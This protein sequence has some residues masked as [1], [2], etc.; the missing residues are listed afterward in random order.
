MPIS[1]VR[2]RGVCPLIKYIHYTKYNA[3]VGIFNYSYQERKWKYSLFSQ[4]VFIVYCLS[5]LSSSLF[6]ITKLVSS[7]ATR[8][9]TDLSWH[10]P[11]RN[12]LLHQSA[13]LFPRGCCR[14]KITLYPTNNFSINKGT[15]NCVFLTWN[16]LT[17]VSLY[18]FLD[19]FKIFCL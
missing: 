16:L 2:I 10:D 5:D 14:I 19:I 17:I 12:W 3:V 6:G 4:F 8:S 11:V 1:L 7:H 18:V 15:N 9:F 13:T